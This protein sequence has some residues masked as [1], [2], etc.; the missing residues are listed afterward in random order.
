MA[1]LPEGMFLIDSFDDDCLTYEFYED[2]DHLNASCC[3][4][5]IRPDGCVE[6]ASSG[7]PG[8]PVEVLKFITAETD[9]LKRGG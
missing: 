3:E 2:P 4:F 1:E 6:I 9:R 8:V 5:V 7:A